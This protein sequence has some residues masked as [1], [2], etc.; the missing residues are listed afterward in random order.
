MNTTRPRGFS[1]W[2]RTRPFWGGLL[3]VLAGLELI[4]I[5]LAP[6]PLIVHQGMAGVASWLIGA[7]LIAAGAL[8]WAQPMLRIFYGIL[9]VLLSIASFLTSNFGG[10][11]LGLLLGVVGGA[12]AVAWVPVKK[13]VPETRARRTAG[14]VAVPSVRREGRLTALAVPA[15]LGFPLLTPT[16]PPDPSAAPSPAPTRTARGM[17]APEKSGGYRVSSDPGTLRASSLTMSGLSYDGVALL[18]SAEGTV[19]ALKFSMT[20]A[21]LK[22]V[23]QTSRHGGTT[24]RITAG[25]L[26]FTGDVA[27]YTT[28]MAS[29]LLGIPVT[30]TPEHPPPL[31][32]PSMVMTDVVAERPSVQARGAAISALGIGPD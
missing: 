10:F 24:T 32:P 21:V 7:I 12:M 14:P 8:M 29:K 22:D 4:A 16:P 23:D 28:R 9:A 15:V 2:R 27:I 20:K 6:V 25:T 11:L 5:P 13:N 17:S 3:V 30:F 18:P 1:R 31:T 26:T 19:R